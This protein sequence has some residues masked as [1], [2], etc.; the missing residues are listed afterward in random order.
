M[1]CWVLVPRLPWHCQ[2]AS[3]ATLHAVSTPL[4]MHVSRKE[5]PLFLPACLQPTLCQSNRSCVMLD[6]CSA[7]LS[8]QH[9]MLDSSVARITANSL[10]ND[11]FG[12]RKKLCLHRVV[13]TR[14]DHHSQNAKVGYQWRCPYIEIVLTLSVLTK[15]VYCIGSALTSC[16]QICGFLANKRAVCDPSAAAW[17]PKP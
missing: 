7:Y 13:L 10:C 3:I 5:L 14:R 16:L 12:Y 1:S 6:A 17:I 11:C 15:R 8:L 9:A 2:L 4:A